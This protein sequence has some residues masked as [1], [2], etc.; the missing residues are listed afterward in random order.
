MPK[1]TIKSPYNLK[2]KTFMS[3][4]KTLELTIKERL[5]ALA[6]FDSFKGSMSTL[7]VLLEDVKPFTITEEEW[8]EAKRE[9]IPQEDGRATWKWDD[10]GVKSITLQDVT[11]NFLKDEIKKKSDANEV[12]IADIGLVSLNQKL[13][14]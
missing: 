14:A 11:A 5:A 9:I 6:I 1:G 13:T 12:T 3:E 4:P 10:A 2:T 7:T 8:T